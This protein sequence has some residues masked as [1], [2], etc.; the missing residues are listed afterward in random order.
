M[1]HLKSAL[2]VIGAVVVLVLAGNTIAIAA[3]G[4]GFLIGKINSGTKITTLK[5]TTAGTALKIQ[6]KS[7]A[8]SPLQVNGSGKVAN[9]NADKL[10]GL[11]STALQTRSYEFTRAVSVATTAFTMT[12]PVPAGTYLVS[13]SAFLAGATGT[14]VGCYVYRSAPTR[15]VAESRFSSGTQTPGLTGSGLVSVGAGQTLQLLCSAGAA[16]TTFAAE[17]IQVVATKVD[18]SSTATARLAP[19]AARV[20]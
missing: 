12:I 11:D 6:T 19:G 9:L 2:T 16:F 7:A 8:N 3:N 15:Y 14:T 18:T 1:R 10:D 4:K 20:R 13:Y 5:R 17:P